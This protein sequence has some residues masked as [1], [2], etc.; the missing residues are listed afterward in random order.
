MTAPSQP[1]Q[2]TVPA[3]DAGDTKRTLDP[4]GIDDPAT[5]MPQT[6]DHV[7]PTPELNEVAEVA[8]P[9]ATPHAVQ[10]AATPHAGVAHIR[11]PDQRLRVFV[12]STLEEL[13]AERA[14]A[15]EAI[16][17]LRPAPSS[18][19]EEALALALDHD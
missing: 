2:E 16:E 1:E 7:K 3:P 15:R 5:S 19:P 14:A 9:A 12:S 4:P 11:T 6:T 17:Q 13:T 10:P 8:N 18:T